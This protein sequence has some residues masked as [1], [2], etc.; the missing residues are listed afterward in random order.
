MSNLLEDASI[1]ITPTGYDN[2]TIN[3]T[4]PIPAL[5]LDADLDFT[6]GSLATRTNDQGLL[7]DVQRFSDELIKNGSFDEIGPEVIGNSDF[8]TNSDWNVSPRWSIDTQTKQAI[9]NSSIDSSFN[10]TSNT[11]QDGKTYLINIIVD[12]ITEGTSL[13]VRLGDASSNDESITESGNYTFYSKSDGTSFVLRRSG[14]NVNSIIKVSKASAKQVDP[15]NEWYL[16]GTAFD[17]TSELSFLED[18]MVLSNGGDSKARVVQTDSL[19]LVNGSKYKVN[20]TIDSAT[21]VTSL[22]AATSNTVELTGETFIQALTVGEN[23]FEFISNGK[24]QIGIIQNLNSAGLRTVEISQ[25]SVVEVFDSNDIP[26][27]DY[28]G[29]GNE[30]VDI[31]GVELIQ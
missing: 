5:G 20:I 21:S 13:K 19:N 2:G 1:V 10:S 18:K 12:F 22:F 16:A 3:A 4:L 25:F 30:F 6:R 11:I 17:L 29:Q 15:N 9:F 14:P 7:E 8:E 24:G 27:I 31:N 26:R 28:T 23:E